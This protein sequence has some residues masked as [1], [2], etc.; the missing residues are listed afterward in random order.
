MQTAAAAVGTEFFEYERLSPCV[1]QN[2]EGYPA[3]VSSSDE[4]HFTT[5]GRRGR[6]IASVFL[7]TVVE[8]RRA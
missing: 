7:R 5:I 6:A 1:D 2:G 8:D 4:V 3:V